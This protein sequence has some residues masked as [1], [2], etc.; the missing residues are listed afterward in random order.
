[1]I[2]THLKV[3]EETNDGCTIGYCDENG[4]IDLA[5]VIQ[6]TRTGPRS[7]IDARRNAEV[8]VRQVNAYQR[9]L[10]VLENAQQSLLESIAM[11]ES[12][13]CDTRRWASAKDQIRFA[14]DDAHRMMKE[15]YEPSSV[16]NLVA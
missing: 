5:A 11:A 8:I 9:L 16:E 2:W 4:N 7:D 1:M 3:L 6:P 15:W 14:L 13:G 10:G 12:T